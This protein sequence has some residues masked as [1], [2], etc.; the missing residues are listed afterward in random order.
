ME[1]TT[2]KWRKFIRHHIHQNVS[3]PATKEQRASVVAWNVCVVWL[4]FYNPPKTTTVKEAIIQW[5][6]VSYAYSGLHKKLK[7]CCVTLVHYTIILYPTQRSILSIDL[8]SRRLKVCVGCVLFYVTYVLRLRAYS[9]SSPRRQRLLKI[10]VHTKNKTYLTKKIVKLV[11]YEKKCRGYVRALYCDVMASS[12]LEKVTAA[13][14]T[15]TNTQQTTNTNQCCGKLRVRVVWY[16]GVIVSIVIQL[17]T[18][19]NLKNT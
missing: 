16:K 18:I 14:L 2:K 3:K 10:L 8:S 4:T 13:I 9:Y 12:F 19:H 1:R 6:I 5:N 7:E 17:I 15:D 11:G